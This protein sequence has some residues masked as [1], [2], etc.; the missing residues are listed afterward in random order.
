MAAIAL[1]GGLFAIG[2]SVWS[3]LSR[4]EQLMA[5]LTPLVLSVI[6]LILVV[7]FDKKIG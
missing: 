7:L 4:G 1:L 3:Q 5:A 2:A 6:L